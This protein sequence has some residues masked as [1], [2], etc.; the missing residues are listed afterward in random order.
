M[1]NEMTAAQAQALNDQIVRA[2]E[3]LAEHVLAKQQQEEHPPGMVIGTGVPLPKIYGAETQGPTPPKAPWH[4]RFRAWFVIALLVLSGLLAV[5]VIWVLLKLP[6][7][8]PP[9]PPPDMR[10][11]RACLEY[12]ERVVQR[13]DQ[14]Q[15][16]AAARGMN[17]ITA[18]PLDRRLAAELRNQL[19]GALDREQPLTSSE[20]RDIR[21]QLA[22]YE[23]QLDNWE[24]KLR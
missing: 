20:I 8:P 17:P 10:A 23:N 4:E 1:P 15:L 14:L 11:T 18:I 12:V 6:N 13:A 21:K 9:P 7:P 19:T 3:I 5:L 2:L 24:A 22:S 16:K